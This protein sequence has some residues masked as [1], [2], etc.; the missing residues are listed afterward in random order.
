[1]QRRGCLTKVIII[2]V[3]LL[4]LAI[5]SIIFFPLPTP[6][7]DIEPGILWHIGG[8]PITNTFL[9]SL[10]ALGVL[11]GVFYAATRKMRLIP[12]GLQNAAE[13]VVEW[14]LNFCEETAGKEN[15]RRFFPI[16]A[17]IFLYVIVAALLSLIPG[18]D[19]V[20]F[21]HYGSAHGG[22]TGTYTGWIVENPI[23]RKANTDV[24]FP[25]ALALISFFC[26]EY[27]G[28]KALGFRTYLS[29]FIRVKQL[30]NG[31]ALLFRGKPRAA[32]SGILFGVVQVFTGLIELISEIIRIISFT[33]RLFGNMTA[34][35]VVLLMMLFLIPWV[36][37]SVFYGLEA[38]FGFV[39]ALI[40]AGLTL[41]FAV[42]A[43]TPQ[44][45]EET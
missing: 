25:L 9:A 41:A 28:L 8:F 6:H 45:E 23:F 2:A 22:F 26:V 34:G 24:N 15:G 19:M 37:G 30:R 7:V 20:G 42:I 4:G 33:F 1:V 31:F 14:L 5:V 44:E 40:F 16:V 17:T 27:W 10:L 32:M 3:V 21:G 35:V 38:F 39:Q 13:M 18:F 11:I 43:V 29:R 36:L 12:K